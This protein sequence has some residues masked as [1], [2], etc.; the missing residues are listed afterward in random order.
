MLKLKSVTDDIGKRV[1]E[2]R[3]KL[4]YTREQFAEL[5]GISVRFT[6][7]IELGQKGMSLDTLIKICEIL[8]VSSDYL[9]WGR[10]ERDGNPI[11]EMTAFLD[12]TEMKHAEELM[13]AYIKAIGDMKLKKN[14]DN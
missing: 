9:I 14:D 13:R 12:D 7:D 2:Y 5:I 6:A 3:E 11:A 10:G 1:R 8:S 4:G